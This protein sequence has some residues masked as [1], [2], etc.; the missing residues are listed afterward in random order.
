MPEA[1]PLTSLALQ[2]LSRVDISS[3]KGKDMAARKPV[4]WHIA[5]FLAPAVVVY[6]ALMIIPLFGT[7]AQSL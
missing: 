4:R 2:K 3:G 6:T 7:L 5:V 1:K